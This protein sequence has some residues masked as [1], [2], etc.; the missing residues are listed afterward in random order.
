MKLCSDGHEEICF[1]QRCPMCYLK[2]EANLL[3]A[4]IKRLSEENENLL[5]YIGKLEVENEE[6]KNS[7]RAQVKEIREIA[8]ASG[9]DAV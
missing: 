4:E 2:E 9:K 6:R 1:S 5:N 7:I 3:E 8:C